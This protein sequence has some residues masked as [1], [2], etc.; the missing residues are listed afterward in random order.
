MACGSHLTLDPRFNTSICNATGLH[1]SWRTCSTP[2]VELEVQPKDRP[3]SS[4]AHA[5]SGLQARNPL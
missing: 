1:R 5:T 4:P 3:L 2:L